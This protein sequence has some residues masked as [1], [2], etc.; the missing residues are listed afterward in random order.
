MT[1]PQRFSAVVGPNGSG[2]SNIIDAMLFVFGKRYVIQL[3]SES[4]PINALTLAPQ[5]PAA[6]PQEGVGAHPQVGDAPAGAEAARPSSE[7]KP[8]AAPGTRTSTS[9]R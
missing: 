8:K 9:P 1:H 6:A 7:R 3:Y 2:K 5:R 4:C